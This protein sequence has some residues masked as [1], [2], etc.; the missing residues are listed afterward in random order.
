[1][2]V[3][4]SSVL[5][6]RDARPDQRV[7]TVVRPY[8][9]F[10]TQSPS[11]LHYPCVCVWRDS[12]FEK[13]AMTLTWLIVSKWIQKIHAITYTEHIVAFVVLRH[14]IHITIH[15]PTMCLEPLKVRRFMRLHSIPPWIQVGI[16]V[17]EMK[18]ANLL[19][20]KYSGW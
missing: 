7:H 3:R 9:Q 15:S 12:R 8:C 17:T 11:S 4:V 10:V 16:S 18:N 13:I 14:C 19:A 1:M 2:L 20:K 6:I 5:T